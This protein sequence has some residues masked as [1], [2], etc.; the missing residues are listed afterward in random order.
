MTESNNVPTDYT[1]VYTEAG[2]YIVT[3]TVSNG[4]CSDVSSQIII[5]EH[6]NLTYVIPNV[7][8]PNGD[9]DNDFLQFSI[10]N[11][12]RV[13][14][15]IYNRWG[16]QVGIIDSANPLLGWNGEDFKSG[17]EVSE[18]VYFYMYE[19]EGLDGSI[20]TGQQYIHLV[21]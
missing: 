20:I 14:V 21:R 9:G 17:Q 1:I 13:E 7:F 15:K 5:V 4:I 11:A 10:E 16:S 8:T 18:G 2:N 12:V 3:L 19:F 6:A